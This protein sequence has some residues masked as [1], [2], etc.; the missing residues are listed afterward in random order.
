[1]PSLSKLKKEPSKSFKKVDYRPWDDKGESPVNINELNEKDIVDSQIVSVPPD[2]ICNWS[3]HDRPESELGNIE[4][5]ADDFKSIGQQQPCIVRP[6][7]TGS[8]QKFE[9]IVGERRWRAS[10]LAKVN[11]KVIVKEI[12]DKE[13]ALIQSAEND[14][15]KDLSDFAKGMQYSKLIE[16]KV[17][18]QKDLIEKL[19]KSKQYISALLSFSKIPHP[20]IEAI[21]DMSKVS[22]KT[23]EYI[24]QLAKKDEKNIP[25]IIKKSALIREGKLGGSNLPNVI[26]RESEKNVSPP[27]SVQK[28]EV[29]GKNK[30]LLFTMKTGPKGAT[31]IVLSK[32]ITEKV[33]GNDFSQRLLL[34]ME[35]LMKD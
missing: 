20:I 25:I 2:D 9:L 33:N 15:R 12:N 4:A 5:L 34:L 6:N 24:K 19:N 29:F 8:M 22:A 14:N 26:K 31:S 30:E 32:N 18:N 11:L 21:G 28:K 35:E 17:I 1:M 23:A 7:K 27:S 3:L 13:A 10:Q 16:M